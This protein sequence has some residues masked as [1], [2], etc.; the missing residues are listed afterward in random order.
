M[1]IFKSKIDFRRMIKLVDYYQFANTPFSFSKFVKLSVLRKK[2]IMGNLYKGA[3]FQV[4]IICFCLMSNHFHFLLKQVKKNGIQVFLKNIQSSYARYFNIKYDR[5]GPVFQNRFKAILIENDSQLLHL[6]RYIHLNPYSSLIVK[7]R[8]NLLF[9][10]WSSFP[11][12]LGREKGFC[13]TRIII[14]QFKNS[15]QYKNFVFDRADYQRKIEKM[16]H[17]LLE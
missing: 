5:L 17:L 9:Y 15:Q 2:E 12:Y 4:E 13:Q 16:K 8:K 10:P 6:S 7:K 11:Q 3:K 14:E 1:P